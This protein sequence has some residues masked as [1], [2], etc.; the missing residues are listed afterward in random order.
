M[1]FTRPNKDR[2]ETQNTNIY[3]SLVLTI[4]KQMVVRLQLTNKL[5]SGLVEVIWRGF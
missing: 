1:Q 4:T 5:F 2:L 3:Y